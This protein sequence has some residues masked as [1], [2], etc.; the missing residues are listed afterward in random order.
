MYSIESIEKFFKG[1]TFVLAG[2]S[3][4]GKKFGNAILKELIK[5]N[6]EVY[7][8]HPE[9]KEIEGVNCFPSIS[10]IPKTIDSLII[11]VNPDQTLALVKEANQNK[12]KNIWIQQGAKSEEAIEY[13]KEKNINVIYDECF[14]MFFEPVE[15][16]HKFHKWLWKILGKLSAKTAA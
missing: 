9:V 10:S 16:I 4:N 7:P 8:V 13:C 6:V 11:V 2:A 14:F 3:R 15:S 5:K 1:K 12:I